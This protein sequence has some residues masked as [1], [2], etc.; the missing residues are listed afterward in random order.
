MGSAGYIIRKVRQFIAK[1]DLLPDGSRIVIGLSGGA[2]SVVLSDILLQ[3]DYDCVAA[4]CNFHL[5]G[6]ESLRDEQAAQTFAQRH[7]IPFFKQDF[8]T[9]TI[10]AQR[11]IS[12][13]MAARELRYA[14]FEQLRIEQN[15]L[16]AVAHHQA[17]NIETFLLNLLR[18]SG[19]RG[20]TGIPVRNGAVVRP[21]LCLSKEEILQYAHFRQ[22]PFVT[23]SSNLQDNYLRNKIRLTLLPQ[24]RA[25]N[26]AADSAILTTMQHLQEVARVYDRHIETASNQVLTPTDD[27][28][29]INIAQLKTLPSP[30]S[31]LF[32]VLKQ[33]GFERPRILDIAMSIDSHSGKRFYSSGHC[34]TRERDCFVLSPLTT[35]NAKSYRIAQDCSAIHEPFKMQ[36]Q[37]TDQQPKILPD[38]R[39]AYLD[40]DKLQFPLTLRR[41][42]RGDRFM[43]FGMNRFQKISDFFNNNKFGQAEKA[44][45]WLLC[46]GDEI[47][48][49]VGQRID[50]RYRLTTTTKKVCI[51]SLIGE[52]NDI[53]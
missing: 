36:I 12:I 6:A 23:D 14:W 24:L 9:P 45:T 48:W 49:I 47:V 11:A 29:K 5:R 31:L 32:E 19:L 26:P 2:D 20:L 3:L 7:H 44:Q 52:K 30:E 53:Q 42:Q 27:G 15:A 16:V 25:L 43:P 17:D 28:L 41:W 1:N 37:H 50:Q 21:L 40:A 38:P 13:E 33:Y 46:S 10:A 51:C 8:D 34:L 35:T 4:H 39:W 18:A 22:L